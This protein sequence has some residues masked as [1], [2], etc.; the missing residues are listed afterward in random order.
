MSDPLL[1]DPLFFRIPTWVI[2]VSLLATIVVVWESCFKL[3]VRHRRP[4]DDSE[5]TTIEA[6]VAG[7]LALILAFSFGMASDRFD[8]R[9]GVIVH[10][11]N[12]IETMNY[13]C[14]FFASSEQAACRRALARYAALRVGFY[15]AGHDLDEMRRVLHDSEHLHAE[16]W[17]MARRS[18]AVQDTPA[19]AIAV[20]TL[21]ELI[22][23]NTERVAAQ[24]RI[25]PIE[26]TMVTLLLCIAWSGFA[27]Y[28][29]G[30]AHNHHRGPWL[31]FAVMISL[32]VYMNIDLDRPGRGFIRPVRGHQS[33]VE[34]AR[35]LAREQAAQPP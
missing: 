25:V 28:A 8:A 10:E 26:V 33:M 32:V 9:E 7:L 6:A 13:R 23:L 17:A 14:D 31:G 12:S 35:K 19:L 5:L 4:G 34:L 24:R 16:L 15:D 2:A 11:A 22:D 20:T 21:N 30:L 27:G 29:C 3:G 1:V 18:Q